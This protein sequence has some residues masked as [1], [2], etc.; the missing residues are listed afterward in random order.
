MYE[1][2]RRVQRRRDHTE[3][4]LTLQHPFLGAARENFGPLL[5]Y[6]E[7]VLRPDAEWA[8]GPVAH[9]EVLTYVLEGE[10]RIGGGEILRT[11]TVQYS[12]MAN[13]TEIYIRNESAVEPA[14]YWQIWLD[15]SNTD[16]CP[17]S[18]SSR[19]DD[20]EKP[21]GLLLLASGQGEETTGI[22]LQQD[23]AIYMS[24]MRANENLIFETVPSRLVFL[25][26]TLGV[27]RLEEN[28]LQEGDSAMASKESLIEIAA[29]G[30]TEL[31]LVDLP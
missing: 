14:R 22:R 11:G 26:V 13:T 1:I 6:Q 28:R 24:R 12:A 10:L 8:S 20:S 17:T 25:A 29:Q 3:E 15:A 21:S 16:I 4:F 9:V 18:V 30:K 2:A 7:T 19:I 31:L 5:Q 27:V 23:S